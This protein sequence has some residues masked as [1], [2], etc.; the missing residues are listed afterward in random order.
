MKVILASGKNLLCDAAL[1]ATGRL[2]NTDE[3]GLE[4]LDLAGWTKWLDRGGS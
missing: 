1:I 2:S 4:N 3:L